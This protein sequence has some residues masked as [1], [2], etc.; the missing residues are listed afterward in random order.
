[1]PGLYRRIKPLLIGKIH[2]AEIPTAE[3][4]FRCLVLKLWFDLS[5]AERSSAAVIR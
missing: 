3:L 2:L 1:M 4:P 5:R